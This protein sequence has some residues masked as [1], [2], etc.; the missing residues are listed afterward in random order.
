[1]TLISRDANGAIT[2]TMQGH[3][4]IICLMAQNA[5]RGQAGILLRPQGFYSRA[6]RLE[7]D[8]GHYRM[9][10]TAHVGTLPDA[11]NSTHGDITRCSQQHTW[12]HYTMFTTAHVGTLHDVHNS[13]HGD[14]TRCSQQHIWGHYTLF[15]TAHMGTLHVVH[16]STHGDIT[17][18]SQEHTWGHYPMFTT[19]YMGTL[20]DVHKKYLN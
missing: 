13:T 3:H 4:F 16:N 17:R 10:T 20:H 8:M 2:S 12:G 7:A 5:F 18:C 14:I 6:G 11:H 15:T 1:M 19:A 9:F